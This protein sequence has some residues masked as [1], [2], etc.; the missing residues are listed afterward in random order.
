[1]TIPVHRW[2]I[3]DQDDAGSPVARLLFKPEERDILVSLLQNLRDRLVQD[4][5]L[6]LWRLFPPAF[7]ND[8]AANDDYHSLM[9]DDLVRTRLESI[10]QCES[11]IEHNTVSIDDLW[12]LARSL[13]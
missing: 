3:S 8:V 5:D 9:H 11:I 13:N 7:E 2:I 4:D 10:E 1:M 12:V 6:S